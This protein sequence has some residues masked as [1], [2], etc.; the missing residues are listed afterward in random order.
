VLEENVPEEHLSRGQ[1]LCKIHH[2]LWHTQSG[3]RVGWQG[4]GCRLARAHTGCHCRCQ[5]G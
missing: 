5:W 1:R 3:Q 2:L 4:G